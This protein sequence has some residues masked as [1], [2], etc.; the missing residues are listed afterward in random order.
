MFEIISRDLILWPVAAH[1]AILVVLYVWL[2]VVRKFQRDGKPVE[3][4]EARISANLSNQ[5][6]APILFY[7]IV[8]MIWAGDLVT[9][10]QLGLAGIFIIGRIW[11]LLVATLSTNI[12]R[13]GM[14]FMVNWLAIY[15]MW[16]AFL[17]PRLF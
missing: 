9:P 11:H 7:A 8:A 5:F 15:G 17:L 1:L 6:E 12:I 10:L 4:L 14:V 3:A 2:S 16:A 13:R